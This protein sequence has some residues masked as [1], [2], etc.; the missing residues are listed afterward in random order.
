MKRIIFYLSIFILLISCAQEPSLSDVRLPEGF[1]LEVLN[2]KVDEPTDISFTA[3]GRML[4]A[5]KKGQVW[6]STPNNIEDISLFTNIAGLVNSQRDRGLTS[7]RA[8]PEFPTKP[9]IYLLYTHDPLEAGNYGNASETG[10]PRGRDGEA[11]RLGQLM[12]VTA[13]ASTNYSTE[14]SGSRVILIGKNSTW[15]NIGNPAKPAEFAINDWSCHVDAKPDG[16]TIPDC[17]PADAVTHTVGSIGFGPDGALFLSQGD[18]ASYAKVDKRAYRSYDLDSLVGKMLRVDAITGQGLPDNPYWDGNPDSNRS[19]VYS[20]GLRNPFRFSIHPQTGEP[21]IGDVGWFDYEEINRAFPKADFG[22][23]C[24]E[25]GERNGVSTKIQQKTYRSEAECLEYF[26]SEESIEPIYSWYRGGQ[27]GGAVIGGAFYTGATELIANE[28]DRVAFPDTYMNAYFFG[29]YET[30]T[31]N[32]ITIDSDNS[33]KYESF[34]RNTNLNA[35]KKH[36]RFTG[37]A[38]ASDGALYIV[39][40]TPEHSANPIRR[41]IYSD[42]L[43]VKSPLP[44]DLPVVSIDSHNDGDLFSYNEKVDVFGSAVDIEGNEIASERLEWTGTLIHFGHPH[45]YFDARGKSGSFTPTDHEDA[46]YLD[47][48]LEAKDFQGRV[49]KTCI[50]LQPKRTTLTLQSSPSGV[51]L[52]Y[53]DRGGITNV[54]TPFSK[55]DV[56]VNNERRISAPQYV[57]IAGESYRFVAWEHEGTTINRTMFSFQTESMAMTYKAIYELE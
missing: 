36:L 11:Q 29:D 49:G 40:P 41:I 55:N 1:Q 17:L 14:L 10:D 7:A 48:C 8:H 31:I 12:R 16:A 51:L 32:Y 2:I 4:V 15:E 38:V 44:K 25:G 18:G 28:K 6:L 27:Q 37:M 50:E 45:P 30:G 35:K 24:F 57:T 9:Y 20:S 46:G 13:D 23:P 42:K 21:W 53:I 43:I 54:T 26:K 39:S 47:L 22:W 56:A 19:K 34:G 3:D 33:V 5:G 52:S